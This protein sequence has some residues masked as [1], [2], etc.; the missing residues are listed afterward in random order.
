MRVI[1][2][3]PF[4]ADLRDRVRFVHQTGA[5]DREQVEK[6]YAGVGFAPDVREFIVDMSAAYAE[7]RPRGLP[8]RSHHAGR[9]HRLQEALDPGPLPAPPPTTT[10]S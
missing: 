3:L 8:R 5:R 10:R 4:L 9:A 1:E 2:A 7:Q 6:G